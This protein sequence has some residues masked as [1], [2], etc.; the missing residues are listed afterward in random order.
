MQT[1]DKQEQRIQG[2]EDS[3]DKKLVQVDQKVKGGSSSRPSG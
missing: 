3:L 1:L 2:K